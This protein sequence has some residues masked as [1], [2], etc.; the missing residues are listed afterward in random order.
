MLGKGGGG[1]VM[2]KKSGGMF[3]VRKSGG[4][5]NT[6]GSLSVVNYKMYLGICCAGK[7]LFLHIKSC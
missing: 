4:T 6:C 2:L 5:M 3:S 7:I 1:V